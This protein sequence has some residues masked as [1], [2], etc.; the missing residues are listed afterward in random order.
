MF[1]NVFYIHGC[2]PTSKHPFVLFKCLLLD[3]FG[4][5]CSFGNEPRLI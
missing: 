1:I 3:F 4:M 2:R 5:I